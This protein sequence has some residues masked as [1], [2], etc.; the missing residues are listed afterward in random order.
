MPGN[1]GSGEGTEAILLAAANCRPA[2]VFPGAL[3]LCR[4]Y[5]NRNSFT[6]D[7]EKIWISDNTPC[8]ASLIAA[9][10]ASDEARKAP[11]RRLVIVRDRVARK[12]IVLRGHG[13]VDANVALIGVRRGLRPIRK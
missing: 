3:P 1:P 13:F 4:T 2:P 5:P 9:D 7:G 6:S 8:P 12:Q 11:Y 10:P